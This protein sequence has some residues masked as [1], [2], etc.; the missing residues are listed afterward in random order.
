[1]IEGQYIQ[2]GFYKIVE[3]LVYKIINEKH[4]IIFYCEW[5]FNLL[6]IDRISN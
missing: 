2:K 6:T 4:W 5:L 1:M 3:L